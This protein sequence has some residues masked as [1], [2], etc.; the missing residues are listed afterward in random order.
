MSALPNNVP[1][2][3]ALV[4]TAGWICAGLVLAAVL[5]GLQGGERTLGAALTSH[6]ATALATV[7]AGDPA[8]QGTASYRYAVGGRTYGTGYV[9]SGPEGPP[10]RLVPGERIQVV[11]DA[12]HPAV[13]CYCDVAGLSKAPDRWRTLALALL[14][15]AVPA[16]VIG[17]GR[18][19]RRGEGGA[20]PAAPVPAGTA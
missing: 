5:W 17:L 16:L 2:R 1:T 12:E 13:S 4:V 19:R 6:G 14:V 18:S 3:T 11:Y 8:G 7:T 10:S 20:L 9:G 15:T